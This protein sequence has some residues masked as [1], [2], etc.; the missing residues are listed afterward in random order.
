MASEIFA[1]RAEMRRRLL[2]RLGATTDTS[3]Y[4]QVTEQ[5]NE[6]LREAVE[7]VRSLGEWKRTLSEFYFNTGIDERFYNYPANTGPGD[8]VRISFWDDDSHQYFMLNRRVILPLFD[9]EPSFTGPDEV[10]TRNKPLLWEDSS[11]LVAGVITPAIELNPRSDAVYKMKIEAFA[12]HQLIDDTTPCDID[13]DCIVTFAF[14][15]VLES[16]GEAARAKGQRD[17]A[18]ARCA[19]LFGAQRVGEIL[20][21]GRK[22]TARLRYGRRFRD[23]LNFDTSLAQLPPP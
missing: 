6:Y 9:N 17:K 4:S 20:R 3:V 2:A 23:P 16:D 12:S 11:Q 10:A 8:I 7:M 22:D 13:A 15:E 1:T 5:Y 19:R 21:R 18:M 14:A